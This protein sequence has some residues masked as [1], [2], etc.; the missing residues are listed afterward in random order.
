MFPCPRQNEVGASE[1]G[2]GG[3]HLRSRCSKTHTEHYYNQD[4]EFPWT[5]LRFP[6]HSFSPVPTF[7][8]IVFFFFKV[9][10][11]LVYTKANRLLTRDNLLQIGFSLL[12]FILHPR[13][14][15]C[16]IFWLH[17]DTQRHQLAGVNCRTENLPPVQPFLCQTFKQWCIPV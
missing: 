9:A 8:K 16:L 15:T 6:K 10:Q 1:K 2:W 11:C 13:L 12:S 4:T 14:C 3:E 5:K 7:Y 17:F